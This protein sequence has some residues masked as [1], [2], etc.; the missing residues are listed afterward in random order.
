M[1]TAQVI[2]KERTDCHVCGHR[3]EA[4]QAVL[5]VTC[6]ERCGATFNVCDQSCN[7]QDLREW[8]EINN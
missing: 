4:G 8:R 3:M 2:N 5:Q 7:L 1:K 6:R